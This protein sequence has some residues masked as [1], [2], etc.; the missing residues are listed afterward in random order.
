MQAQ[1]KWAELIDISFWKR[2]NFAF[3]KEAQKLC[4]QV[5]KVNQFTSL[6]KGNSPK[7]FTVISSHFVFY[8]QDFNTPEYL[9][10]AQFRIQEY[11][12]ET[13]SQEE[14]YYCAFRS[15]S[16][17][18]MKD[19]ELMEK[20]VKEKFT[21]IVSFN[22]SHSL[23]LETLFKKRSLDVLAKYLKVK[24]DTETVLRY[25]MLCGSMESDLLN[26]RVFFC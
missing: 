14:R 15:N 9:E 5:L 24:W 4:D 2:K 3:P 1:S 20:T 13:R 23:S 7:Y 6:S 19:F 22:S 26:G 16:D 10:V 21:V 25:L 8:F 17:Q 18:I 11:Q 12:F